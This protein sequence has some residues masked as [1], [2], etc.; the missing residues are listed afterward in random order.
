M[1]ESYSVKITNDELVFSAAHFITFEGVCEP[2]HGHNYR[3]GVEVRGP[4]DD[5]HY[6]IDFVKLLA[7]AKT[8]VGELDH[9]TLV[10]TEH[11][12]IHVDADDV[13]VELRWNDRRWSFPRR[14]C[15][16][17]SMA[18]TTVERLAQHI[19]RRLADELADGASLDEIRVEVQEC[20][21]QSAVW[22]WVAVG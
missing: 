3:V 22:S 2:L 12:G 6:V 18:N 20:F 8:L 10:P 15:V 9:R 16:L 21:G 4:L 19:G 14:D 13:Q 7:T 17:L 1:S 5:N 11:P